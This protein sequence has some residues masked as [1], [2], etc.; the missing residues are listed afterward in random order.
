MDTILS[1]LRLT[2]CWKDNI[3]PFSHGGL[4]WN[5]FDWDLTHNSEKSLHGLKQKGNTA[6]EE[7]SKL[8]WWLASPRQK[9]DTGLGLNSC[10]RCYQRNPTWSLAS[11]SLWGRSRQFGLV[12]HS[13]IVGA[14]VR[15][16][17][18]KSNVHNDNS[19]HLLQSP[20]SASLSICC[21]VFSEV[22]YHRLYFWCS[23]ITMP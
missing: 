12:Q 3:L 20:F 2:C 13:H 1:G 8:G 16:C 6:R 4:E 5:P 22:I 9:C 23:E 7:P 11:W 15:D 21:F 10:L 19:K 14:A 18:S 17:A